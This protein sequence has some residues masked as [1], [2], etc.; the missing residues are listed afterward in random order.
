MAHGTGCTVTIPTNASV[1]FDVGTVINIIGIGAGTYTIE[2]DTGVTLNGVSGGSGDL[3]NQ[4]QG[5]A[6]TKTATNT[7]IAS[8]DIGAVS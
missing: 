2:G 4:Y 1:A 5:V 8:G 3:Q 6:L 7:W